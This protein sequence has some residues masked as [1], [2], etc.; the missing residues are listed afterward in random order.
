MNILIGV[1]MVLAGLCYLFGCREVSRIMDR[2]WLKIGLGLNLLM[3]GIG[4]GIWGVCMMIGVPIP[5][6]IMNNICLVFSIS[7]III[8]FSTIGVL[9]GTEKHK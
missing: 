3:S 8:F 9:N 7:G 6:R 5:M 4:T 2:R 1:V